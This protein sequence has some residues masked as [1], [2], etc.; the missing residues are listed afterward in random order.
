MHTLFA[1]GQVEAIATPESVQGIDGLLANDV[2]MLTQI[3]FIAAGLGDTRQSSAIFAGL[4]ALRPQRAFAW[5]GEATAWLNAGKPSEAVRCLGRFE[6][7]PGQERDMVQA[8]LGLAMQLDGQAQAS[9]RV[10]K[11]V[12]FQPVDP[13]TEGMLLARQILGGH[14]FEDLNTPAPGAA[15]T[16][17]KTP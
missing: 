1:S 15:G 12:A 6:G 13:A 16:F 4:Q 10:L 3:G 5:V 14:T 17:A 11:A 7:P 8:F 2:Q 9:L